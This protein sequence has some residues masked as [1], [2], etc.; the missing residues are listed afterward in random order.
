MQVR[1][2]D[3][4]NS[5]ATYRAQCDLSECFPD[6]GKEMEAARAALMEHGRTAVGGG[7]APLVVLTLPSHMTVIEQ[8][9]ANL[10]ARIA[11]ATVPPIAVY[12]S[13]DDFARRALLAELVLSAVKEHLTKLVED[14]AYSDP[15]SIMK[16]ADLVRS[17]DAHLSDL[18]GDIAG[19][20]NQVAE[21]LVEDRY[22]GCSRGPMHRVRA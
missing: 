13:P 2:F 4:Q 3:L 8:S 12:P 16:D 5:K 6:G 17:I 11:S 19:T 22:E 21:R 7:A 20:L 18:A 15:S 1:I 14:A 9:H 10:V